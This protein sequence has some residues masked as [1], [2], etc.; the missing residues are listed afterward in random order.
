MRGS[1]RGGGPGENRGPPRSRDDFHVNPRQEF[2]NNE[3]YGERPF[4][5]GGYNH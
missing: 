3:E 1:G 2:R 5:G 4:Y